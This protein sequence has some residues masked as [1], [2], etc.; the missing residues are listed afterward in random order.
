MNWNAIARKDVRD[1]TRSK[2]VWL[3]LALFLVLF[4]GLTYAVSRLGDASFD[5]FLQTVVD[6]V[7]MLVPLVGIV[8]GYKSVIAERESGTIALLLSLP[9]SRRDVVVGTFLG[10]SVVLAVPVLVGTAVAGV[11]VALRFTDFAPGEYLVF[12]GLSV[13]LGLAFLSL[14][15]GLSAGTRSERRVTWGAFGAYLSLVVLWNDLVWFL[16]MFL[17]RFR[18]GVFS[19]PPSWAVFLELAAPPVAFEFLSAELLGTAGGVPA[20]GPGS[21]WFVEPWAAL[22]IL[23]GWIVVPL[24]V[25]YWRFDSTDL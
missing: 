21:P 10:R 2:S 23:V 15:I 14:A 1:A 3:L 6:T 24:L 16:V 11:F 7:V 25:G 18:P 4:L 17:F 8:L 19:D 9:H 12:V 13:L 20:S 22:V 5:S